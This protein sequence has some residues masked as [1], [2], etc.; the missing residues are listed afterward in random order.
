MDDVNKWCS[1]Y[2]HLSPAICA[3]TPLVEKLRAEPQAELEARLGF[4]NEGGR[5][6]TGVSRE[7]MD[8]IIDMMQQSPHMIGD[9]EWTEEQDFFFDGADGESHRTRV[10]YSSEDM[11]IRPQTIKKRAM[12]TETL[13]VKREDG[14][15]VGMDMRASLK[16]EEPIVRMQT[17]VTTTLVRIKQRRRFTTSDGI[18]AFDFAMLWSGKTKTI[19]EQLQSSTDPQF[20]IECEL[21]DATKALA[22]CSDARIATSLLLKMCDLLPPSAIGGGKPRVDLASARICA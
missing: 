9:K 15:S 3:V 11:Q 6:T 12:G 22:L 18:W 1:R 16:Y 13:R 4:A 20:E 17:C 2:P 7:D 8:R 5:F 21:I 10:S 14:V 19:A